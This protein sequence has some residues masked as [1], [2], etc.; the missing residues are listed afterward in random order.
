MRVN[1]AEQFVLCAQKELNKWWI[2][3]KPDYDMVADNYGK[4]ANC[5]RLNKRYHACIEHHNLSADYHLKC[6]NDNEAL[7]QYSEMIDVLSLLHYNSD[8][9]NVGSMSKFDKSRYLD[10]IDVY[11]KML[12]LYSNG[13]RFDAINRTNFTIA[14]L[15]FENFD[16]TMA[17]KY[18]DDVVSNTTNNTYYRKSLESMGK[19]YHMQDNVAD[20]TKVYSALCRESRLGGG[21]GTGTG[22]RFYVKASLCNICN[23]DIVA[24]NRL[25]DEVEKISSVDKDFI[26][27]VIQSYQANDMSMFMTAIKRYETYYINDDV[28]VT[29][30]LK[31][32]T[33]MATSHDNGNLL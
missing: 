19:I 20:M 17:L 25:T 16:Y 27:T 30:L 11:N 8:S 26:E 15:Y 7:H 10:Q 33:K 4:A 32:K 24:V 31:I 29:L 18:Y 23:D 14:Q 1:E 28:A 3:G 2:F 12:V 6:N 21:A 5:F 9:S 13:G 22:T